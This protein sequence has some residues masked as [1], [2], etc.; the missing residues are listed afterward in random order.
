MKS[1]GG[2]PCTV[3]LTAVNCH[4]P[5][6]ADRLPWVRSIYSVLPRTFCALQAVRVSGRAAIVLMPSSLELASSWDCLMYGALAVPLGSLL[7]MSAAAVVSVSTEEATPGSGPHLSGVVRPVVQH[8]PHQTVGFGTEILVSVSANNGTVE[9]STGAAA[10]SARLLLGSAIRVVAIGDSGVAK[11]AP[12]A[13]AWILRK[14]SCC[15]SSS[16]RV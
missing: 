14:V 6:Q 7:E 13:A 3:Q 11:R 16:W 5:V 1:S 8:L 9:I 15:I 10:Q 12:Y 2:V 4:A